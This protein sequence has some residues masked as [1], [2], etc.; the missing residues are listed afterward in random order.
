MR[1]V[2]YKF[3]NAPIPGGGFVTGLLFHRG[4]NLLYARTDVGGAYRFDNRS[5]SW[6]SFMDSVDGIST[7]LARPL[8]IALDDNPDSLYIACGERENGFLAIS[9]NRGESFEMCS[10]PAHIHGNSR[11]RG[12]GERLAV[13]GSNVFF[14]STDKGLLFSP[15][16]GKTW[17][18]LNVFGEK[19]ITFVHKEDGFIVVGTSGE[20]NSQNNVR[21]HSVYVSYNNGADFEPLDYTLDEYGEESSLKGFVGS[22]CDFDGRYLY[23]TFSESGKMDGINFSLYACDSGSLANGAVMRF[24][25]KN[26][27]LCKGEDITPFGEKCGFSGICTEGGVLV[28]STV[29]NHR[30][31]SIYLSADCGNSW[32]TIM[33]GL[34]VGEYDWNVPYM[35]PEYN[36]NGNLVHWINDIK[37]NP[38]NLNQAFFTTGTGIFTTDNLLS[39]TVLWR[40][41][42]NGIE[43][44]VHLNVYAPPSGKVRLIDIVGDLG[45]FAFEELD[46]P[47]ENSFANEKGDRYITCLNADFPDNNP[48]YVVCTPR[49]N[50]VGR[51]KGGLILSKDNC[52]TWRRLDCPY[53]LSAY[54]DGLLKEIEKPNVNSGWTAVSADGKA[55]VWA[56]CDRVFMPIDGLCV[57]FDEGKSWEKCNIFDIDGNKISGTDRYLKPYSDRVNGAVFYGIGEMGRLYVSTDYGRNF[58]EIRSELPVFK[59]GR[60]DQIFRCHITAQYG[61]SGVL[62]IA[63]GKDGLWKVTVNAEQRSAEFHR[64]T[65][66]FVSAAGIGKAADGS[67]CDTLFISGAVGG[68]YGFYRSFDEGKSW[69]KCGDSKHLF[70]RINAMC[71]DMRD[72]GRFYLA[73]DG[74]GVIYADER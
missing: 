65:A 24:E 10:V 25:L 13:S 23:I 19:E 53:G 49:G 1:V 68:E 55:I 66:E 3:A 56:V 31:D 20:A 51:T 39:E 72:F 60:F 67:T 46:K 74:R 8:S 11:G 44:T 9:H 41:S 34:E 57:T 16:L 21:G 36:N 28:T 29:C 5:G 12:M 22:H 69:E 15:D 37:I 4:E 54:I 48:D 59:N 6:N 70:G 18:T 62:W 63:L 14:G 35:K 43:E 33:H 73:T 38:H 47:C 58:Y 40:P 50:W 52:R 64:I 27:R 42:C 26:G 32:K 17:Q 30:G 7:E 61:K 2:D 45:G 71:G